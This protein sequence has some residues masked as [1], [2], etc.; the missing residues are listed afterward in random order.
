[1]RFIVVLLVELIRFLIAL[2]NDYLPLGAMHID[3]LVLIVKFTI[4]NEC[5]L[6]I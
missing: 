5:L 6:S 4:V 2:I 1:M 3:V